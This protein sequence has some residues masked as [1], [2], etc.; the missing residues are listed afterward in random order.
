MLCIYIYNYVM[1]K[2]SNLGLEQSDIFCYNLLF[3][4]QIKRK[5]SVWKIW[6]HIFI[7]AKESYENNA[8]ILTYIPKKWLI[9]LIWKI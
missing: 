1:L 6:V 4:K 8:Y 7:F 5:L 3:L 9:P 2:G